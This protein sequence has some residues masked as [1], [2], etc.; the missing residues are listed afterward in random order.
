MAGRIP[1]WGQALLAYIALTLALTWPLAL[2]WTTDLPF[3]RSSSADP[4]LILVR[5]RQGRPGTGYERR[6]A[7]TRPRNKTRVGEG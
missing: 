2:R 3:L 6:R 7:G 5:S 1:R 4:G